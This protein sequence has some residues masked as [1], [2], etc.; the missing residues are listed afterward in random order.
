MKRI[1]FVGGSVILMM[2]IIGI[3]SNAMVHKLDQKVR[4]QCVTHDWPNE[5][6]EA[7]IDWCSA[8][9]YAVE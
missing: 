7:H 2:V 5:A 4:Q 3:G 1:H 6:H 8:N 9:G